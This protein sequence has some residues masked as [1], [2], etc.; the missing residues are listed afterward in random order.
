MSDDWWN[1]AG[2]EFCRLLDMHGKCKPSR[3]YIDYD[4][5][6]RRIIRPKLVRMIEVRV[7]FM[8]DGLEDFQ[9]A[10]G[11]TMNAAFEWGAGY[12]SAEALA[13]LEHWVLDEL[14][15]LADDI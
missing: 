11:A 3:D 8:C 6:F 12:L 5:D 1:I 10:F 14:V 13:D 4:R 2:R 7:S 9:E 15:R